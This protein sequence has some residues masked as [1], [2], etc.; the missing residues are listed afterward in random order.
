M[1]KRVRVYVQV[2]AHRSQCWTLLQN[3]SYVVWNV[4]HQ[5]ASLCVLLREED[6][7]VDSDTFKLLTWRLLYVTASCLLDMAACLNCQQVIL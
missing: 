4:M 7:G 6:E 1:C 5:A 3:V 2:L